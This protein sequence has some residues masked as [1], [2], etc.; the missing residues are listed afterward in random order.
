MIQRYLPVVVFPIVLLIGACTVSAQGYPVRPIRILAGQAPGGATDLFAR[1]IAQKLNDAWKNPVVV[2][3]RPGAAGG[4]AAQLTAQAPPDGYT[5]L[6]STA[7]QIVINPHLTRRLGYD[8]LKD[9]VPV[10]FLTTSPLLLVTHPSVPAKSVRELIAL[11]KSHPNKLNHGSGGSGSP[12]HLAAELFKSKAGIKMVHIPFKGVGPSV[13]ALAAGEIDC[14]FASVAATLPLVKAGR[15]RALAVS[16]PKRSQVVPDIPTVAEA[17]VP[18]YEVTTWYG[19]FGP[20][21]LPGN[22]VAKLNAEFTRILAMPDV[23]QRLLHEGAEPGNLTLP[24]FAAFIRADSAR[25][26]KAIKDAGIKAD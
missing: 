21:A 12:A 1:M 10:A 15:L 5:M 3:N 19:F 20:A 14:T 9:L 13:V 24:Q 18:G 8:P 7:G 22:I 23:R 11:A 26:A 16:T 6:L 4:I 25:W 17:G 2:E